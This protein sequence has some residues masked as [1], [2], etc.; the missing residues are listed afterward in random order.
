ML[1]VVFHPQTQKDISK[2]PRDIRL[3][4]LDKIAE[5]EKLSHPLQHHRVIKLK[6]KV[7]S[8]F[9]NSR[10]NLEIGGWR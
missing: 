9:I 3:A 7:N 4:I 1:K 2:I 5:L 10:F 6:F 8:R